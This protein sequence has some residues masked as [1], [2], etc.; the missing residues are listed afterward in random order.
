M[1]Y[2]TILGAAVAVSLAIAAPANA[3]VTSISGTPLTVRV[4]DRGQLQAVR[5]GDQGGIFYPTD[6]PTGDAGFFLAFPTGPLAGHVYG[7][8]GYAGP[9]GLDNYTPVSQGAVTGS[10]T[11]AAPYAV[12]TTYGVSTVATVKQT[13][14]YVNGAQEFRVRWEVTNE[15]GAPL[16]FKA[17]AA[18]DFY[19]EGSDVGTGIFSPGPPRFVGGTN[20]N[21]G[22][23]GGF[24][25]STPWD[26]WEA[27]SWD[28]NFGTDRV[29]T[30][31]VEQAANS[32]APSFDKSIETR[33][34][35]NA[36]G[37][38]W[39]DALTT[40]LA[41]HATR[42]Y[43]LL[44]RSA[45]PAALQLDRTSA[46]APRGTPVTFVATAK[47]TSGQPFAGKALRYT[48]MGPNAGTGAVTLDANG[49]GAITDPGANAGGDTIA[50]YLDLNGNGSRDANEPQAGVSAS[51]AAPAD[52]VPPACTAA[53][54]SARLA[55][56]KPVVVN[57]RCDTPA[58]LVVGGSFTVTVK[59]K[60][61]VVA[62]AAATATQ[63]LIPG[64]SVAVAVRVP[65]SIAKKYAGK[66]ATVAVT[67]TAIDAAGN[68]AT[69]AATRTVKL[70]TVKKAAKKK[71]HH[72]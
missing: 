71:K 5:A 37:V 20:T 46:S 35:D 16:P 3:T 59:R 34:T 38:E 65:S 13:T 11:A 40:P 60:K 7:F 32:T 50:V 69:T 30:D 12:V 25:E 58:N 45:V 39:D 53:I 63:T 6:Q 2:K 55:K 42:S 43:E 22:R 23:S 24:I 9:E 36:G 49:T 57:V 72:R 19:F 47:D 1:K 33:A 64:R 26:S 10:G 52:T 62:K 61:K 8:Q 28:S 21:T 54:A 41:A 51:F 15:S 31:V 18:A 14:S 44:V 70:A 68:K 48:I 17:L 67:V 29:W 56:G 4:T 66:P 27:L